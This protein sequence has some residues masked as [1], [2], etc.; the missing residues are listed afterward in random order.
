MSGNNNKVWVHRN[1]Q[2]QHD[3]LT[4]CIAL[5]E[6]EGAG[7]DTVLFLWYFG[8]LSIICQKTALNGT[9]IQNLR[10]YI[11][12]HC[13]IKCRQS[14]N[15]FFYHVKIITEWHQSVTPTSSAKYTCAE[16]CHWKYSV[17]ILP[18]CRIIMDHDTHFLK[19]WSAS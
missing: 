10:Q 16:Q 17:K 5:I 13:K 18:R 1:T 12:C 3:W 6:V 15:A 19:S 9:T 8:F 14:G 2:P 11:H 7:H 4:E